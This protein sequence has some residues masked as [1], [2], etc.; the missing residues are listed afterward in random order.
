MGGEGWGCREGRKKRDKGVGREIKKCS[1]AYLK[2]FYSSI[3]PSI[4]IVDIFVHLRGKHFTVMCLSIGTP[5]NNEFSI[6]SNW[7]IYY[8]QVSQNL[9]T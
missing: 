1:L 6:F 2:S 4:K 3:F 8:F 7:K 9:G 5:K